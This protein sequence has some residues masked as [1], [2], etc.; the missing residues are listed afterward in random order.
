LPAVPGSP[1]R[2]RSSR[3]AAVARVTGVPAIA[4][5]ATIAGVTREARIAAIARDTRARRN[6]Y[7]A[8]ETVIWNRADFKLNSIVVNGVDILRYYLLARRRAIPKTEKDILCAEVVN[9]G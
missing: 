6:D 2:A 7:R 5:V 9:N 4:G 1:T 3:S 8:I